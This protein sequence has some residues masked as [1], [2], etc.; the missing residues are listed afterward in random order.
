MKRKT[1]RVYQAKMWRAVET[2]SREA[3]RCY[4]ARA[5]F[6]AIVA[7]SCELEGLLRIFDFVDTSKPNDRCHSFAGL[8][9]RAFKRRWIPFDLLRAW[10]AE[11]KRP[12]KEWLHGVRDVRNGVHAHLFEKDYTSSQMARNIRYVARTVFN[13]LEIRNA[14][15][16]MKH[17]HDRGDISDDE[18]NAW[19]KKQIRIR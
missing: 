14:R 18:Y 8:V 9:D 13:A 6:F 3:D 11:T 1:K 15:N 4:R 12:L 17:L 5:Y 16:F 2:Y 10:N 19:K 7:W